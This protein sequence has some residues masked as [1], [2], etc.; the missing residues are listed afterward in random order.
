MKKQ[1]KK[2]E[3]NKTTIQLLDDKSLVDIQG[4]GQQ[5]KDKGMSCW[6]ESCNTKTAA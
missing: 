6:R 1:L 2:L 5:K 4:G 3:L